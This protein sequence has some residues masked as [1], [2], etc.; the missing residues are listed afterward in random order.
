MRF[1]YRGGVGGWGGGGGGGGGSDPYKMPP[2]PRCTE[3]YVHVPIHHLHYLHPPLLTA[4]SNPIALI[5]EIYVGANI[6]ILP[7]RPLAEFILGHM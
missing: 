3:I 2:L 5:F 6:A 4:A 1:S 7:N